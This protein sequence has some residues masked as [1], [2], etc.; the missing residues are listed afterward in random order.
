MTGD[1]LNALFAPTGTLRVVINTG[2][3]ILTRSAEDGRPA[4][5]S[6]DMAREFAADRSLPL[7][8]LTVPNAAASVALISEGQADLGFF[9][10]DPARATSVS[11]TDPWILIEGWYLVRDA[12]AIR[13]LTQV[14]CPGV[15]IAVGRGSAYD[16]FLSRTIASASLERVKTS[17]E[18]V[19]FF[20]REGYEVAAGIRQQLEADQRRLPGLRLLPER[21]MVIQQALGL[22]AG[23]DPRLTAAV[24]AFL[25]TARSTGL[26]KQLLELNK[27]EGA[28]IAQAPLA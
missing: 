26:I 14:D 15:R 22:P 10:V 6:V 18:V 16:L 13:T 4:G 28:V 5:I 23:R 24:N 19:D 17:Q 7:E 25:A 2:N 11:F 27:T 21:F 8:L 12:S 1:G 9:A 20:L 3:A